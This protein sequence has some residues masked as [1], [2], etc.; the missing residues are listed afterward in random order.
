[1]DSN[2][3]LRS[4][5]YEV[6]KSLGEGTFG[7]V[8]LA[9]SERHPNQVAIKIMQRTEKRPNFTFKFLPRE[10]AILR[11][12]RHPHIV[13]VHEIIEMPNGQVYIVME[14]L[15][16]DLLRK[17]TELF[18]IPS[19]QAK[20]WFSQLLSA[21]GYLHK[22]NIAHRDIKCENVLL[23]SDNQVKL[24][25]FGFGCFS[26][27][28]PHLCWTYCCTPTFAA[29]EV[30]LDL[31]YDPKKSD[32]WSLGVI[33][34]AMITGCL[35]FRDPTNNWSNLPR[36]QCKPVGYPSWVSVEEPCR[37]LISHI[38]RFNPL[39][40]PSVTKVAQHPW[41]QT[42]Q[43]Q[44]LLSSRSMGLRVQP[45]PPPLSV[46]SLE[47]ASRFHMR[48]KR[49]TD[50]EEAGPSR[51]PHFSSSGDTPTPRPPAARVV[52]RFVVE[53]VEDEDVERSSGSGSPVQPVE[54]DRAPS[55]T[56]EDGLVVFSAQ[57]SIEEEYQSSSSLSR[58]GTP[59]SIDGY[60]QAKKVAALAL[61][62]AKS[63]AWEES[64]EAME[65]NFRIA[66]R[67]FWKRFDNSE[68]E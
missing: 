56:S 48:Q 10:L 50:Q 34:Y 9:T 13:R 51:A 60:R 22:Q 17:I 41:L 45:M 64:G 47:C 38:L 54:E 53:P 68:D 61:A 31:P 5:G 14:A 67:R 6:V 16:T 33:L 44:L 25:D 19:E 49:N 12:V 7:K 26:R 36:L 35:P 58:E 8:K 57:Q 42:N 18:V 3:I 27:G 43:E 40:R 30:L 29:P 11:R 55:P 15:A 24:T 63:R 59:N 46:K 52:G 20:I 39:A 65:N 32:V 66:S 4:L 2:P 21:V 23:T 1:M 28:F 62:E 37:D